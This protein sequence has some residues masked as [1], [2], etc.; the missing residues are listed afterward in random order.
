MQS[1]R[2]VD[3]EQR[4]D[5]DVELLCG[6]SPRSIRCLDNESKYSR[7]RGCATDEGVG[8]ALIE[9]QSR[10]KI[11]G[12]DGPRDRTDTAGRSYRGKVAFGNSP[13]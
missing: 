7:L 1:G 12:Q 4:V 13:V 3:R 11:A 8:R 9:H 10:W 6:S 2:R 5:G